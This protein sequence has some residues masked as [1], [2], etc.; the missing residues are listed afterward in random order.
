M[1]VLEAVCAQLYYPVEHL[2]WAADNQLLALSST[3]LWTFG[4]LLWIVPLLI[5]LFKLLVK[6]KSDAQI[7]SS[8]RQR[9]VLELV[10]CLCDLGLAV[11][12]LPQGWLWGG[13]LHPYLWGLLGTLSSLVK[14]YKTIALK[15]HY[16]APQ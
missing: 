9:H 12:W 5:N 10:Q 13:K 15:L 16:H 3:H 7:A 11:Y 6:L 1:A 14:L 8:P 4:I 2:A